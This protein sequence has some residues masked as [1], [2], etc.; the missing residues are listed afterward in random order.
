MMS[1]LKN[2]YVMK[3][4]NFNYHF[5]KRCTLMTTP[6]YMQNF[7]MAQSNYK[8]CMFFSVIFAYSIQ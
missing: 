1:V 4:I 6:A 3:N 2:Q 8:L 5:F 7:Q